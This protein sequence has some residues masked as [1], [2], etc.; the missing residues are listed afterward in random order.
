MPTLTGNEPVSASNLAAALGA[1][2]GALSGDI[3]DRPVSAANLK[4]ALA[5]VGGGVTCLFDGTPAVSVTISDDVS[6]Y[7][8][9]LVIARM[10]FYSTTS[11]AVWPFP[12]RLTEF[13]GPDTGYELRGSSFI[14]ATGNQ[15]ANTTNDV[16]IEGRTLTINQQGWDC[17]IVRVYGIN[18][19]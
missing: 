16:F 9:I 13:D 15:Y 12:P 18:Y 7:R 5:A 1:G 17:E 19:D 11:I 4:A 3:G 2:G 10:S 8:V 6:N 14:E